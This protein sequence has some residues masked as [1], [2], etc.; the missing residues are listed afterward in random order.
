LNN[1]HGRTYALRI[2][3]SKIARKIYVLG[4]EDERWGIRGN[5]EIKDVLQGADIV[6]FIKFLR[7]RWYDH[8][9]RM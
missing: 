5:Q 1:D 4:K 2:F 8:V 9:E 7:L 3:E 6:K